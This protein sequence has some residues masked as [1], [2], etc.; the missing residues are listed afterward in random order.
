[1]DGQHL[2]SIFAFSSSEL[3]LAYYQS[4]RCY[5]LTELAEEFLRSDPTVFS[6]FGR[7]IPI[8]YWNRRSVIVTNCVYFFLKN[9]ELAGYLRLEPYF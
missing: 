1:M 5:R 8:V 2:P 7:F 6:E 3:I 9:S 4:E